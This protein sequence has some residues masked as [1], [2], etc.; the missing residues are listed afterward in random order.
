MSSRENIILGKSNNFV[1]MQMN[2]WLAVL[3]GRYSR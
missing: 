3:D 2:Y 1:K